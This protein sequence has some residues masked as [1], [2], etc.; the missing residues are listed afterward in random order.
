MDLRYFP[1]VLSCQRIA[2]IT[3]LDFSSSGRSVLR[4]RYCHN[5][6][7]IASELSDSVLKGRSEAEIMYDRQ[8]QVGNRHCGI[9]HTT[10]YLVYAAK[11]RSGWDSTITISYSVRSKKKDY[12]SVNKSRRGR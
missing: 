9:L 8:E 2:C 3:Q 4:S 6:D 1:F 10:R 7:R 11:D 5:L 12:K